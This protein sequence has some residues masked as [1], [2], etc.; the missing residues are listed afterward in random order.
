[1]LWEKR[2]YAWTI[3]FRKALREQS[4]KRAG[5]VKKVQRECLIVYLSNVVG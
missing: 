3:S 2:E 1:M 5:N 4:V